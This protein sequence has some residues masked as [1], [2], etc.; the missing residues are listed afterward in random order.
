M[1]HSKSPINKLSL[2]L[3]FSLLFFAVIA[4]F[5][6][7]FILKSPR[8][9]TINVRPAGAAVYINDALICETQPCKV[10]KLPILGGN[11]RAEKI[12]YVPKYIQFNSRDALFPHRKVWDMSLQRDQTIKKK[13]LPYKDPEGAY[14]YDLA[15]VI[16]WFKQEFP[17]IEWVD[18]IPEDF[19]RPR[20]KGRHKI[21][22]N[23]DGALTVLYDFEPK[24]P[25]DMCITPCELRTKLSERY[26]IITSKHGHTPQNW[27]VDTGV[28]EKGKPMVINLHQ[29]W[30]DVYKA[31]KDCHGEFDLRLDEDR[32]AEVCE[33]YPPV[34]PPKAENSGH[35]R[36]RF[37]VLASGYPTNV[38]TLH[39]TE[40]LFKGSSIH[41]V[42]TWYYYPKVEDG[43]NVDS[44]GIKTKIT[45]RLADEDGN[46][47]PELNS[48]DQK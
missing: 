33:R 44:Y 28:W 23:I 39:C 22:T 30:L 4:A 31:Q 41:S 6:S 13:P 5:G 20:L 37:D 2:I 43:K 47:I 40:N 14:E 35:C 19:K 48:A 45:F 9:I 11:I 34:M 32:D 27:W 8:S 7:Y 10:D 42:R 15:R 17:D 46:L 1:D 16:R 38:E 36:L 29:N 21:K 3:G 24:A 25:L 18:Y 26:V 12:G